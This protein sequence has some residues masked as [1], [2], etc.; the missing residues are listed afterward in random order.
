MDAT[1]SVR[2]WSEHVHSLRDAYEMSRW[3]AAASRAR[4]EAERSDDLAPSQWDHEAGCK[5]AATADLGNDARWFPDPVTW[6]C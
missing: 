2:V 6:R 1:R 5:P 3:A 4:R